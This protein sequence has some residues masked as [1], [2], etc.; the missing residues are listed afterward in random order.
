VTEVRWT[1]LNSSQLLQP[2]S[3]L[4]DGARRGAWA[5]PFKSTILRWNLLTVWN[6]AL[7]SR[8]AIRPW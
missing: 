8:I 6:T 2:L 1:D 5:V 3:Q 4:F 7:T